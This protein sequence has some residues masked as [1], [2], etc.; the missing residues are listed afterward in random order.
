MAGFYAS[1]MWEVGATV[2]VDVVCSRLMVM[3]TVCLAA[4]LWACRSLE[5]HQRSLQSLPVPWHALDLQ[6]SAQT[7]A[8]V[9]KAKLQAVLKVFS[10]REYCFVTSVIVAALLLMLMLV[11]LLLCCLCDAVHA[12]GPRSTEPAVHPVWPAP[13]DRARSCGCVHHPWHVGAAAHHSNMERTEPQCE[14]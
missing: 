14:L 2:E 3:V 1:C 9:P 13:S 7:T 12:D 4:A 10:T 11:P 5:K 8:C 6:S